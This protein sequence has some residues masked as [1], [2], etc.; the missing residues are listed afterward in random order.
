MARVLVTGVG[1]NV[2]QGII[3]GVKAN[4]PKNW[5][6]GVDISDVCA[7]YFM[8]NKGAKVP[9]SVDPIYI[10]KITQLIKSNHIDIVLLGVDAELQVYANNKDAIESETGCKIII[11]DP[12]LVKK[13][14]DKYLTSVMLKEL[15]LNYPLTIIDEDIDAMAGKL[16]FP[17]VAKPRR[18]NGS[19]G[20]FII[21]SRAELL[22]LINKIPLVDYCFQEFLNGDEY[23]C[24]LLYDKN[25]RFSDCIVMKRELYNGTTVKASV[26]DVPEIQKLI[27]NFGSSVKA[28]GSINLQLKLTPSGPKIFEI[29]PR[30]SGTTAFRLKA[31]YNDVGRIINNVLYNEPIPRSKPKKLN[32]FRYW[33]TLAI[34]GDDVRNA[35][36]EKIN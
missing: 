35:D 36:I 23:T 18:G 3:A 19:K 33:E 10:P 22:A 1:S 25:N 6:L 9:Y 15:E 27:D 14:T 32:F 24:G 5:I 26:M 20:I 31:G 30:F 7:G 28:F 2:G 16:G 17:L 4:D 21:H 29:N 11:S 34:E 8:C 13:C 12:E